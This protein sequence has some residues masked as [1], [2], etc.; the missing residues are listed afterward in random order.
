MKESINTKKVLAA[1]NARAEKQLTMDEFARL[2]FQ[3]E[4][5]RPITAGRYLSRWGKGFE[6]SKCRP[7]IIRRMASLSGLSYDEI[8]NS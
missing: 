7:A 8:F 6:M 4:E 3:N 1:Y 5:R 2:V